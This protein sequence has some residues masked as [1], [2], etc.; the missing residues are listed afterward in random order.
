M[1]RAMANGKHSTYK[2]GSGR[3]AA[4]PYKGK[5]IVVT[6]AKKGGQISNGWWGYP[7]K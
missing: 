3:Q 1:S 6:C 4:M 2:K 7:L 5:Y